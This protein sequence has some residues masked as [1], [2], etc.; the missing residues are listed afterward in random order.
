MFNVADMIESQLNKVSVSD[1]PE[2]FI[3]L[4][5]KLGVKDDAMVRNI[6]AAVRLVAK[7]PGQSVMEFVKDGGLNRLLAGKKGDEEADD[8][9]LTCPH[10]TK[11]IFVHVS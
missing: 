6:H 2:S 5:G 10:C 8:V 1:S 3:E 7:D 9:I 11:T 4:L